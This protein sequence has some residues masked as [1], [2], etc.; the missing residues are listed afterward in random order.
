MAV[1]IVVRYRRSPRRP[2]SVVRVGVVDRHQRPLVD[3]SDGPLMTEGVKA[4]G[5]QC[6]RVATI[7]G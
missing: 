6:R 1:V 3:A 4:G 5:R 7:G 2:V